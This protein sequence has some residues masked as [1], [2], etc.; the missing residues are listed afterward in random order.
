MKNRQ[1]LLLRIVIIFLISFIPG[2]VFAKITL[3]EN[4][5]LQ[6]DVIGEVEIGANGITL[7]CDGHKIQGPGVYQM[8]GVS[9]FGKSD[10]TIKNC[11]IDSFYAGVMIWEATNITIEKNSFMS[12]GY[13]VRIGYRSGSNK[14]LNNSIINGNRLAG[15]PAIGIEESYGSNIIEANTL[16]NN[17]SGI[18]VYGSNGDSLILNIIDGIPGLS[19]NIGI[20]RSRNTLVENNTIR[21]GFQGIGMTDGKNNVFKKNIIAYNNTGILLAG[22]SAENTIYENSIAGNFY[23]LRFISQGSG[24]ISS[25]NFIYHNNIYGNYGYN[26][27]TKATS[28]IEVSFEQSGNYWGHQSAPCFYNYGGLKTPFDSN[29]T[30]LVDS[31]SF[32]QLNGWLVDKILPNTDIVSVTDVEGKTVVN[33]G[34][35]ELDSFS[36]VFTGTDNVAVT[37]FECNLDNTTFTICV[38]PKV[39]SN[40]SPGNHN[41]QVRAVDAAGNFDLTPATFSWTSQKLPVILLPGILGSWTDNFFKPFVAL[42]EIDQESLKLTEESNSWFFRQLD[43][44]GYLTH[45]WQDL[46]TILP[47]RGYQ[48]Y[49]CPYDW[50]L[51]NEEIAQ[52]Y[53][54]PCISKAKEETGADKVNII[55]HSMGGLIARAY[56]QNDSLYRDNISKLAMVGTPNHGSPEAYYSWEGGDFTHGLFGILGEVM[57]QAVGNRLVQIGI[58]LARKTELAYFHSFFPS[59]QELLPTADYL[60]VSFANLRDVLTH[61]W[62]NNFLSDI[63]SRINISR[64]SSDIKTKIFAAEGYDTL[65]QITV[66]YPNPDNLFASASFLYPDGQPIPFT[67]I[68]NSKGDETVLS[69]SAQIPSVESQIKITASNT[70]QYLIHGNLPNGFAKEIITFLGESNPPIGNYSPRLINE[71]L[72][73]SLASPADLLIIDPLGRRLGY[74][75][76]S[77]LEKYQI[78]KGI[79]SGRDDLEL[80]AIID[81]IPGKYQVLIVGNGNGEF[82]TGITYANKDCMEAFNQDNLGI[83]S[84]GQ[85]TSFTI[86]FA[87]GCD[88]GSVSYSLDAKV[89]IDP[90][91]LSLKSSGSYITA[92]V[93]LPISYHVTDIDKGSIFLNNQVKSLRS[94]IQGNVL[95]VKFSRS[96]VQ[97]LLTEGQQLLTISG[98]L[99]DGTDWR[100]SDIIKVM[101]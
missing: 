11:V 95:M 53:L 55:A 1:S 81:P 32:C 45:S 59:V 80:A 31:Y 64:L 5:I 15:L 96:I 83:T 92:Y 86:D 46:K 51:K 94:E 29:V 48:L 25:T 38:I 30:N 77:Q 40:I 60:K 6:T 26:V 56:V 68:K 71:M 13:G 72:A 99:S 85:I 97:K 93:Q 36:F 39:Y 7:D 8:Y 54:V 10:V 61:T 43:D 3:I 14:V 17:P 90:D 88:L 82:V 28:T 9:I 98:K 27:Y 23:G 22:D 84:T 16:T 101:R 44:L 91:T 67:E 24:Q 62:Q 79:Y 78:P 52:K 21:N 74:D 2:I 19:G 34:H 66:L 20:G 33:N 57:E 89:N 70:D 69:K 65:D 4:T 63:N 100:T 35:S 75:S 58:H 47:A 87:G 18:Y 42:D 49:K 12:N 76:I 37:S 41:F 50:R 73:I